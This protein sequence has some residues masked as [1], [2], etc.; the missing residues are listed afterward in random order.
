MS[1]QQQIRRGTESQCNAM[2]PAEG[3]VIADTTNDELRLGDGSKAGGLRQVSAKALQNQQFNYAVATGTGDA[4]VLTSPTGAAV[5]SLVQGLSFE[6]K[7]AFDN[8][9]ATTIAVDGLTATSLQK[10][11]GSGLTNLSA[12]DLRAGVVYRA[13]YNGTV[14]QLV[15]SGGGGVSSITAGDGLSGGTITSTGSISINTNNSV[16]VGSYAYLRTQFGGGTLANGATEAGSNL[17]TVVMT[18]TNPSG[19]VSGSVF[20][21]IAGTWRNVSGISLSNDQMAM[22]IR[23]A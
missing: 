21:A 17:R 7:A 10:P 3:E 22:F 11:S 13:T 4:I 20:G 9:G 16:G 14:F 2:T 8:T 15:G 5:T 23:V 1:H 18:F 6:F 19:V 12:G